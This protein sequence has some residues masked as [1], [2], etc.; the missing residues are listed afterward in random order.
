VIH[1]VGIRAR[2]F[3]RSKAFYIA[4]LAPLGVVAVHEAELATEFRRE[5]GMGP[6]FFLQ[7][8]LPTERVHLAFTASDE[9]AVDAFFVA[10]LGA[11]GRDNGEPGPRPQY[12][13]YAALVLD[14]DG[15]N[16][17]AVHKDPT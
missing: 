11:G 15:N 2:D 16:I 12:K 1:H 17:E 6:S 5:D 3:T 10:A 4:A 9:A 7:E 8:G 14:P 13:A